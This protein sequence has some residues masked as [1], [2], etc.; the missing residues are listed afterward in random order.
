[1]KKPIT[2]IKI[3]HHHGM[4]FNGEAFSAWIITV[5]GRHRATFSNE[6]DKEYF[7]DYIKYQCRDKEVIFEDFYSSKE[8]A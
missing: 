5:D 4:T 6:S 1:M 8:T 2:I 3:M 7:L